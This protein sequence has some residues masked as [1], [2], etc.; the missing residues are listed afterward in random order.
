MVSSVAAKLTV[1]TAGSASKVIGNG[2]SNAST[3]KT[4]LAHNGV[5][6]TT[7]RALVSEPHEGESRGRLAS[8]Q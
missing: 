3:A 4:E 7:L 5:G 8:P 1:S 6:T 2:I